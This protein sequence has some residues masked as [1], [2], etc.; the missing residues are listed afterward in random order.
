VLHGEDDPLI[1]IDGG[2]ALAAAIP[3]AKLV[4]LPGTGHDLPRPLWPTIINEIRALAD[5][6]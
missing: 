3:E 4:T 1:R 6:T 5:Q 2:R